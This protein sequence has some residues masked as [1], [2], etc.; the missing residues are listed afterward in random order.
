M[1]LGRVTPWNFFLAGISSVLLA[2]GFSS[3]YEYLGQQWALIPWVA[4]SIAHVMF[5]ALLVIFRKPAR[6]AL[7]F[8]GCP[9][10]AWLPGVVVLAGAVLLSF[11]GQGGASAFRLSLGR[12]SPYALAT[13]TMIPFLEE[14]V[15]RCG[16]S[17]LMGRLVGSGWGIWFGAVIFSLIHTNPTLDRVMG[18]NIGL[19]VGPF[20]LAICSDVILRAWGRVMPAVFFHA[21]C[22]ATV[23]I[24]GSL[25]PSW[26]GKL[27]GLYI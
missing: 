27:G 3:F 13:L 14:M 9:L 6:D 25:N 5:V 17:P 12:W 1:S 7:R 11:I 8:K 21:C 4:V 15:F 10:V 23:Y 24:F 20:I 26:L 2:I 18:L 16:I 19:P 22:N